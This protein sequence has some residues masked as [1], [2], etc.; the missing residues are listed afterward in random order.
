[1]SLKSV[2]SMWFQYYS[3]TCSPCISKATM[4]LNQTLAIVTSLENLSSHAFCI[5][6][7]DKSKTLSNVNSAHC[8]Q[9]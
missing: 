6:V 2:G 9:L 4:Q 3:A 1:M 7:T 8:C 5:I